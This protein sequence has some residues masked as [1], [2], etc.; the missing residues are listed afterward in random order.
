MFAW[1]FSLPNRKKIPFYL[2]S[3]LILFLFLSLRYNFGND[4]MSY[5]SI[6]DSFISDV[7][8]GVDN[9]GSKE[10]LFRYLN[11]L[12]GNYYL[13]IALIS[14]LYLYAVY[15]L[16]K[17]NLDYKQ[18]W[19]AV[20]L[21]LIN[22]YLFLVHLS[23]IRETIAMCF[24]IFAVNYAVKRQLLRYVVFVLIASGFHSSALILLPLYFFFTPS[25]IKKRWMVAI[26]ALVILMLFTPLFGI[27]LNKVLYYFPQYQYYTDGGLQ[28]SIRSTLVTSFF[29]FLVMFNINKLEGK[30]IIYGKLSLISTIISLLA[31]KLTMLTRFGMYFEIFLIV[32][33]PLIFARMRS[34]SKKR[35][36]FIIV[37]VIYALKYVSFFN[38]PTFSQFYNSYKTILG[39]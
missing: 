35:L 22:P 28:N 14:A 16:I 5:Y 20:L 17:K 23:S 7:T 10:I 31:V 27:V 12:V 21:L 34:K 6:H 33:I 37:I 38:N 39:Y 2:F 30:E 25:K 18:Y 36:L 32:A 15:Y 9:W 8:A 26:Y 1:I 24:F 29:F 4:Y 19:M 11:I 13:L 3:F